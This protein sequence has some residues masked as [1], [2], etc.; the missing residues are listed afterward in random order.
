M[1]AKHKILK[2]AVRWIP[3]LV[4]LFV[5]T[6]SHAAEIVQWGEPGGATDIADT[7]T[8]SDGPAGAVTGTYT[9]GA[10]STPMSYL[11][12]YPNAAGRNPTFNANWSSSGTG[13]VEVREDGQ[14]FSV[15]RN[16]DGSL[17]VSYIWE[18]GTSMTADEGTLSTFTVE[19]RQ[20]SNDRDYSVRFIF[21]DTSNKWYISEQFD[22]IRGRDFNE[23]S[24]D[25]KS[26]KWFHYTPFFGGT[27]EIGG[28]ATPDLSSFKAV[29]FR[30]LDPG[31]DSETAVDVHEEVR[32]RY[33]QVT[34]TP[35]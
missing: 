32:T 27:D 34:T 16:G 11:N 31:D 7:E 14:F 23:I 29:G 17:A 2:K 28:A 10:T 19:S 22:F 18:N 8:G 4:T 12:Y 21:Q 13:T 15:P 5:S 1:Q 20:R 33:F 30:T 26:I 9:E 25:A 24:V 6:V 35:H 3:L